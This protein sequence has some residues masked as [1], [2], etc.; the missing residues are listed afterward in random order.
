MIFIYGD[1]HACFSF[2]NITIP[3]INKYEF[4][5]TMFRIGRDNVI[6]NFDSNDLDETNIYC[7]N[8][9][10][11]DCRCHIQRQINSGREEDD[12]ITE[13]VDRYF[14]TIIL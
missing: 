6:I 12:I 3:V 14:L 7:F 10:E 4:S 11:V 2:K 9:G 5:L 1:S 13:L 8:Y